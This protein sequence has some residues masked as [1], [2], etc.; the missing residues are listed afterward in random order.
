LKIIFMGTP[1]FG[2]KILESLL[3]CHEIV[4]VVTQPDKTVGRKKELQAS[5]VKQLAVRHQLK[6]FQ[7]HNCRQDNQMILDTPA[8]LIVTAAYGQFL[9]QI[10]LNH[11]KQKSINVHGSLLPAY[12]GGAP[13]QR[14]IMNGD[15]ITG[16]TIMYMASKM[17]AGDI[18]YQEA[19][20]IPNDKNADWLFDALGTLGA[21]LIN[22]IIHQLENNLLTPQKQ[23]EGK[24][25]FAPI[26]KKEEEQLNFACPA[27][28]IYNQIRGLASNP[29]AYFRFENE[30]FKVYQSKRM[31]RN[32][33]QVPGT[34]IRADKSGLLIACADESALLIE[35]L[36]PEG[37]KVMSFR[38]YYNGK[39]KYIFIENRR[40]L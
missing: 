1:L 28:Q 11:P 15:T 37:R 22:P 39:G 36:Q 14:A 17:D 24:V 5:P 30:I 33:H 6:L 19:I 25:T 2:A 29:G 26:I 23:D 8:D 38:D 21:K 20:S 10:V 40:I 27:H 18:L 7:P 12:R 3:S 13:V 34:I 35:E 9:P 31:D 4:L 16:I 32:H